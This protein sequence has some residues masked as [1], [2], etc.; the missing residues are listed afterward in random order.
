MKEALGEFVLKYVDN[1]EGGM[2]GILGSSEIRLIS[3][4]VTV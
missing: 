4:H 1:T 3:Q 2:E